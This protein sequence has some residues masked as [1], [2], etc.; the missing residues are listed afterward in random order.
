MPCELIVNIA[1]DQKFYLAQKNW[2]LKEGM[3]GQRDWR[4]MDQTI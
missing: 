1:S 2:V 4:R 3:D